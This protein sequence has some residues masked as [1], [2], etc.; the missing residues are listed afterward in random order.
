MVIGERNPDGTWNVIDDVHR[1]PRLGQGVDATHAIQDDALQRAV[2]VLTEYATILNS[3]NVDVVRAVATSAVRD[4]TNKNFVLRVLSSAL[5]HPI[6]VIDGK[7]EGRLTYLGSVDSVMINTVLIDIGG[8]STEV[9]LGSNGSVISSSSI[10]IGAVR[11]TDRYCATRP[12]TTEQ[13]HEMR[14][15]V[16]AA[17]E[18][19][20]PDLRSTAY[21]VVAV[22]G[23]A[24][25]LAMLDLDLV[26]FDVARISGHSISEESV[27]IL[28]KEL[29]GMSAE[30]LSNLC[31]ID[32]GRSDIL[33]A[34]AAILDEI[35]H[36]IGTTLCII[37]I[38][39]LRYGV[40]FASV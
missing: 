21:A 18:L 11:Y 9:V 14:S 36:F 27:H 39:G 20:I 26:E 6:D 8:G 23:T 19:S 12:L 2:Y 28:S 4:A 25:S 32:R 40:M 16:R 29:L 13:Q 38:R 1:I 7:E 3:H 35:L 31:G 5:G 33:P 24:T 22:A 37:S 15:A 10:E 17:L 30:E 34:G